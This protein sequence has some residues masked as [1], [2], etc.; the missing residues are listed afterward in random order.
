MANNDILD[1][2]RLVAR[3]LWENTPVVTRNLLAISFIAWLADI[4]LDKL[5]LPLSPLLGLVNISRGAFHGFGTFHIWQPITYMFMHASFGHWFFNMLAVWMFGMAIEREWGAKKY[6]FYYMACG[7][8]AALCQEIVWQLTGGVL[9]IGASGAVFGIL[10]AFA[11]LFPEQ[12]M[13]LLFIP[14]PIPSRWFVALYGIFELFG[15]IASVSGDNI[16][17]FA[18][19][20]GLATGLLI[21]LYWKYKDNNRFRK[22]ESKDYSGYHYK[23]PS[24]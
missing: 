16:A 18:H 6:L 3:Q 5:G 17:H 19:L 22:Y 13:F 10:A 21:L 14:I 12:R 24:K 7:L 1:R 11:W 20:G 2:I 15:G 9:T 23:E 4:V 8:G